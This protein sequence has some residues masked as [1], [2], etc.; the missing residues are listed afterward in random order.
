MD[1]KLAKQLKEAGLKQPPG[2]TNT[3]GFWM[4]ENDLSAKELEKME[5]GD[6]ILSKDVVYIP[7]LS[8]LIEECGISFGSL[9]FWEGKWLAK[10]SLRVNFYGKDYSG[11]SPEEAVAKLWLKVNERHSK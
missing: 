9:M 6:V 10:E 3:K 7:T 8:E 11:K 4:V 5:A 2:E 1:Y